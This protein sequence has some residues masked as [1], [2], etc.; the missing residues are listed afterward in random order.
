MVYFNALLSMVLL[1]VLLGSFACS[2]YS[3]YKEAE[4]EG[5]SFSDKAFYTIRCVLESVV[6]FGMLALGTLVTLAVVL[7][8][9]KDVVAVFG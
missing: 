3:A 9:W 2:G 6:A 7:W 8:L 4:A 1:G 5:A